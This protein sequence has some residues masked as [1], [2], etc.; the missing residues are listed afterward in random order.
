MT[1]AEPTPDP[2]EPEYVDDPGGFDGPFLLVCVAV[3]VGLVVVAV[4]GWIALSYVLSH[5]GR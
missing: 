2:P 5:R 3:L 4:G 1:M